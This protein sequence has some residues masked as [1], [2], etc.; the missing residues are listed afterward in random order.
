[1][2][3]LLCGQLGCVANKYKLARKNTPPVQPLT[4]TFAPSP[5]LQASLVALVSYGG[6]GSWKRAALWD[7]Y[8][9]TLENRGDRPLIIAS[10]ALTDAT[11]TPYAASSDLWALEKQSKKLEKEYRDRGEAFLR[12]AGSGVLIVGVAAG[13]ASATAAAGSVAFISPAAAGAFAATVIV[14]PVYYLSVAGINH[15]NKKAIV[16]EF[17][18]R[19][20]P[21]PLTLAPGESRTGSLFFPMV[22]S[23]GLL[24]LSWSNDTAGN[25][26]TLPLE[27]LKLLHV[28]PAPTSRT[29]GTVTST[30]MTGLE[31]TGGRSISAALPHA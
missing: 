21:L 17:N 5:P 19:R 16:A 22:R 2:T 4:V 3:A 29:I 11:G 31:Q 6:P 10:A 12:T 20:L 18:R 24:S 9:V 1:M 27:F 30:G 15:H 25:T 7:E 26:T 23:P 14:L 13:A 28:P 8:V